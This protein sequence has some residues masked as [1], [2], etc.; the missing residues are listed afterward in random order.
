MHLWNTSARNY[1]LSFSP[2]N[3]SGTE[4]SW[5]VDQFTNTT[6]PL[7]VNGVYHY[8]FAITS[9][10][11][12]AANNRFYVVMKGTAILPLFFVKTA[13]SIENNRSKVE[14]T[15]NNG[16]NIDHFTIEKMVNNYFVSIGTVKAVAN[17]L[18]YQFID[19]QMLHGT[20]YF[21]VKAN[22][23]DG[24]VLYSNVL[25][26]STSNKQEITIYPNPVRD[27]KISLLISGAKK[28]DYQLFLTTT[29]GQLIS[30]YKVQHSGSVSSYTIPVDQLA[31]GIY[32]LQLKANEILITKKIIIQ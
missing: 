12:S 4:S 21:R 24:S 7:H 16:L 17:L 20:A 8:D 26:L 15:V 32:Q 13:A 25:K 9:N 10:T 31:K 28:G 18:S 19:Q 30:E 3:F 22:N 2:S 27:G 14:W 5:L 29:T 11:A 6:T 23:K 1:R